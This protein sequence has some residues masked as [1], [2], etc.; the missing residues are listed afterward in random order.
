MGNS[1]H[2]EWERRIAEAHVPAGW[3][4]E[5]WLHRLR[6]M[7]ERC[8]ENRPDQADRLERWAASI[9]RTRRTTRCS[10]RR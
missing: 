10:D 6:Q 3:T 4:A 7:V 8:R 1:E 9:E 5:T 2:D